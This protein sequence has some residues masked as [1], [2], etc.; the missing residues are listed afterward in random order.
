MPKP[1]RKPTRGPRPCFPRRKSGSTSPSRPHLSSRR[2][3]VAL[4]LVSPNFLGRAA[5]E[6]ERAQDFP[7]SLSGKTIG[8]LGGSI[9]GGLAHCNSDPMMVRL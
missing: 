7:G 3:P 9:E 8:N 5:G 6:V 2:R 1:G 4:S